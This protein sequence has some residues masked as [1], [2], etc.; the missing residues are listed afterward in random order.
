M[1]HKQFWQ[2]L[3]AVSLATLAI[4]TALH[5]LPKLFP[6]WPLS[7]LALFIFTL[8]SILI[9]FLGKRA[10]TASNKHLFTNLV[11]GFTLV[12]MLLSGMLVVAYTLLS[13]PTNKLFV[14]PFFL[15]Y[16]I[17]TGL[18]VYVMVKLARQTAPSKTE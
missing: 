11:M 1:Q 6:H 12:K 10:A 3:A 8:L 13:V 7:L 16:A 9:F 14:L 4:S 5:A 17:Y 18:E 2:L 15:I